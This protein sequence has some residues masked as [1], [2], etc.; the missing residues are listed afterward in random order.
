[1][2]KVNLEIFG[3]IIRLN[4]FFELLLRHEEIFTP[5]LF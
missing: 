3:E 4:Q 2:I 5:V 1:M